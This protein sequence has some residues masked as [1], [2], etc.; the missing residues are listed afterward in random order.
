MEEKE[1]PEDLAT[2]KH[3]ILRKDL[4]CYRILTADTKAQVFGTYSYTAAKEKFE[5]LEHIKKD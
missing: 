4:Y 1:Q 5:K 3:F 2:G